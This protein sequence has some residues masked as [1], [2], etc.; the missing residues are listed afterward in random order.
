[1]PYIHTKVSKEISPE[2]EK[3][4]KT[5][6]GEA[7]S[8]LPGKSEQWLMLDFE[9]QCHMYFQGNQ[10]NPCAMVEVKVFGGFTGEQYEALTEKI[11]QIFHQVLGIQ[12]SRIYVT[13]SEFEHWGWNGSNF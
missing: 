4:L 9:Q 8:L 7:I 5:Q 11:S 10:N 3:S 2:Q 12:P 6:L 1:M 13:Y